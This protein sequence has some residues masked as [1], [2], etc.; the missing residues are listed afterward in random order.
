MYRKCLLLFVFFHLA[1]WGMSQTSRALI[2]AIEAYP[3]GSGWSKIHATNDLRL[4]VPLLTDKGYPTENIVVLTNENATKSSVVRQLEALARYT[5]RGDHVY[6]HFSCH[7][8][9]MIDD[10]GDEP[11]GLDEALVLYDAR[12]RFEAGRYE[13]ENHLRDDEFGKYLDRIRLRAGP[14]GQVV[15]VLDACHSGTADRET[16]ER[17]VRGTTYI[18]APENAEIP[19]PDP[20]KVQHT[21]KI[22]RKFSPMAVISACKPDALNY[23]YKDPSDG[24]YYG[25]LSY[26]FCR[27]VREEGEGLTHTEFF[28]KLEEQMAHLFS[29]RKR[30]QTPFCETTH[31]KTYS[32][33]PDPIRNDQQQL[34]R[35][36]AGKESDITFVYE[37]YREEFI[38]FAVR[39]FSVSRD[40]A[41]DN[42]QES[43][44]ALYRNVAQG[45][46]TQLTCSLKTYLFRIGRNLLLKQYR[47][48]QGEYLT[49]F[50]DLPADTPEEPEDA[51]WMRKQE[52]ANQVMAALEEP[53]HTVLT[54]YYWRRKSMK[55][56]A[57]A[58]H[59]KNDQVA[60]NKREAV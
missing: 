15:V 43:F 12:R 31:E 32:D 9:Q 41:V 53:C 30:K 58:L 44:L 35:L 3:E 47:Q 49:V 36:Y 1:A 14:Q 38:R 6:I 60:K 4:V 21:I 51:E 34:A 13:G 24:T 17:Y 11:D 46:L 5:G 19:E 2:V 55:E 48:K 45:K 26:A 33:S 50:P 23:E 37:L 56:I 29:G 57:E 7:G 52:I 28:R 16:R 39:N 42:Y 8:Q 10:N 27:L 54:L 22:H 18:F 25:S 40:E 59:Y 20:Q